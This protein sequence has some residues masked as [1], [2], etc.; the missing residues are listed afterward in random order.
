M[1][2]KVPEGPIRYWDID[3]T[4]VEWKESSWNEEFAVKIG[5]NDRV[6]WKKAIMEHVNELKLQYLSGAYNIVW[7]YGGSDWAEAVIVA[8]E[9]QDYVHVIM[10]K[11]HAYYDDKDASQWLPKRRYFIKEKTD[12]QKV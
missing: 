12:E 2:Y 9:L 6:V 8:L 11:P 4:L 1:Y 7:S 10:N 3:D 5:C